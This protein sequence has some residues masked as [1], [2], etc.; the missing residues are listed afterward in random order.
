[1]ILYWGFVVLTVLASLASTR[2]TGGAQVWGQLGEN[3]SGLH[4]IYNS[5]IPLGR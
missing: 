1:M 4:N 2:P 5:Y 3:V